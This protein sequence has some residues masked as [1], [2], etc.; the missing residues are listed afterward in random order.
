DEY[1]LVVDDPAHSDDEAR[2][3]VL[4]LSARLRLAMVVHCCRS[5]PEVVRLIS[6]QPATPSE[7]AQ[8]A[9][10]RHP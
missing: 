2:F 9:A 5:A 3:I 7:R 10:H 8:Y 6:A 1:A 4:G